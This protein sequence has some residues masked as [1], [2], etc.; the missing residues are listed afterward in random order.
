MNVLTDQ[1]IDALIGHQLRTLRNHRKL[2]L[3]ILAQKLDVS[4]QQVQKYQKG[5]TRLS[6]SKIYRASLALDAPVTAFFSGLPTPATPDPF[7]LSLDEVEII[8]L[9][10]A[11]RSTLPSRKFRELVLLL[12]NS[13]S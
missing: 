12:A 4:Y 11:N 5:V 6:G 13:T 9:L 8:A 7:A 10:R 2:S 3:E 1:E